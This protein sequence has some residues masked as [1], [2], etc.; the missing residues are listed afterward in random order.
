MGG[1]EKTASP[2]GKRRGSGLYACASAKATG[3]LKRLDSEGKPLELSG[4]LLSNPAQ[5][6]NAAQ[7]LLWVS[8]GKDDFLFDKNQAFD[9]WLTATGITRRPPS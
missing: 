6:F 8:V 3:A 9:A 7:K 2:A 1:R 5:Q 4:P